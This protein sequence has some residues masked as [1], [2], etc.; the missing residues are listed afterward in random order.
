M[1]KDD[2]KP[3]LL[4]SFLG[5]L[6]LT[7]ILVVVIPILSAIFIEPIVHDAIGELYIGDTISTASLVTAAMLLIFILFLLLLG[8]GK[9]FK[10]YGVMGVVGLIAA[11]WYL[12][13][14]EDAVIPVIIILILVGF[15]YLK[16]D[17]DK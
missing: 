1:A 12:D 16:G 7:I 14:I 5:G 2:K 10:K 6:F 11:Y 9:I 3:G 4:H 13:R 17:K 8:G 15:S